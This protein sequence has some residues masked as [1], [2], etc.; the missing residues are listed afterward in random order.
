[1]N[2]YKN[3]FAKDKYD[4]HKVKNYEPLLTYKMINIVIKDN[5]D[6]Q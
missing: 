3:I 5:I 4:V 1:M 2:D 6:V